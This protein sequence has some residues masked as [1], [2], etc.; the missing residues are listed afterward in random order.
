MNG[1]PGRKL[2]SDV[3][4]VV[5]TGTRWSMREVTFGLLCLSTFFVPWEELL[6]IPGFVTGTFFASSLALGTAIISILLRGRTAMPPSPLLFLG[7]FALW[8]FISLLWTVDAQ[9]TQKMIMTYVSL[10]LFAWMLCEFVDSKAKLHALLRS[11]LAGCCVAIVMLLE[12]YI[13]GRQTLVDDTARYTGGGLNPNTYALIISIGIII[14]AYMGTVSRSRWRTVYWVFVIPA[15]VS[16]L[17]TGSRAGA[18]GLIAALITAFAVTWSGNA[19]AALLLV[20]ALA[21]VVWLIPNVIPAGLL[22]RVTEGT[23]AG[24]FA[25]R[26]DQWRIGLEVWNGSPLIGVGAGGFV[27]AAVERGGR[28][29]VAHN[30]FV[31][32]L[33]DNGAVG[34]ALF[35]VAWLLLLRQAWTL[36][37]RER[38]L[39]LGAAIVWGISAVTTS[40]EYFKITWLLYAWIMVEHTVRAEPA[41]DATAVAALSMS[42]DPGVPAQPSG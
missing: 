33:T 26:V 20:L 25:I 10:T 30:T 32:V 28:G 40:L 39:W 14:A 4:T 17:L 5:H 41:A 24:T 35:L 29:L 23:Q 7:L 19:R 2:N 11:Y 21:S 15:A 16:V 8:S 27:T 12:A 38:M 18:V 22:E 42:E 37:R 9:Q 31:Q 6:T 36:P 34:M 1:G 13:V 3:G